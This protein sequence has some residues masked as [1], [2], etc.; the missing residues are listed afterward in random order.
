MFMR[1]W[2]MI[3]DTQARKKQ[4]SSIQITLSR[5]KGT[6]STDGSTK[7]RKE[8][9]VTNGVRLSIHEVFVRVT[10][11]QEVCLRGYCKMEWPGRQLICVGCYPPKSL[12]LASLVNLGMRLILR[13]VVLPHPEIFESQDVIKVKIKNNNFLIILKIFNIHFS[14]QG[15]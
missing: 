15:I 11:N 13:G 7:S 5:C 6:S 2:E 10:R 9:V 4:S 14:S 3:Q 1:T 8:W 12:F